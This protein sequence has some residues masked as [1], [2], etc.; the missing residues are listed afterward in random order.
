LWLSERR[1]TQS[2]TPRPD[3]VECEKQREGLDRL[4]RHRQPVDG[5][6]LGLE[7]RQAAG[8]REHVRAE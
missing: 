3:E 5:L 8:D 7:Q 1:R 2:P 4:G 6:G